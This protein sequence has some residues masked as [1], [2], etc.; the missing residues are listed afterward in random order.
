MSEN[1]SELLK[2][3]EIQSKDNAALLLQL[4]AKIAMMAAIVESAD[5]A[6]FTK[7]LD[8][9]LLSWNE[10]SEKMYGY[11]SQQA[12]GNNISLIIPE[13]FIAQEKKALEE[14]RLDKI[15]HYETV[16]RRKDGEEFDVSVTQSPMKDF[17][18][19]IFGVSH[20]ERN[21]MTHKKMEAEL[22][23]LNTELKESNERF[24]KIFNYNLVPM[25]MTEFE[26][27]KVQNVN[28]S[29]LELFGYTKEEVIGKTAIELNLHGSDGQHKID[30]LLAGHDDLKGTEGM[31]TKKSGEEF[32]A[33]ASALLI[34]LHGAKFILGSF[35]DISLR[36]KNE[37]ALQK[38]NIK[39]EKE[40]A[41]LENRNK[42]LD[43]NDKET[44]KAS[45]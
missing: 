36:K 18:A 15:V 44:E 4:Q 37:E 11:E 28:L 43:P 12:I 5:D 17:S 7:S 26:T 3:A 27:G 33:F 34:Y 35:Q 45:R 41:G 30:E 25:I 23:N 40:N 32:W 13:K 20:I 8:G 6:I 29:F 2:N 10:G 21:I 24:Y 42:E 16:R 39:L 14:I 1:I 9:I 31:A 38:E 22:V 19:S